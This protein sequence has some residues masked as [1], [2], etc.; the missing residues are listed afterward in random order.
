MALLTLAACSEAGPGPGA[1]GEEIY[2]QLCAACHAPDLSGGIGP[3][4]GPGSH[5]SQQPDEFLEVTIMRGRGRMPSFSTALDE[6][7]LGRLIEHIR[8]VQGR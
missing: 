2:T 6:E 5:A 1:T 8:E 7:Q 4:L 3:P